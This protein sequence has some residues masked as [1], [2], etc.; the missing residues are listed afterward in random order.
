MKPGQ[1]KRKSQFFEFFINKN[2][3]DFLQKTHVSEFKKKATM[4]FRDAANGVFDIDKQGQYLSNDVL[5]SAMIEEAY[6]KMMYYAIHC[7]ALNT[8]LQLNPQCNNDIVQRIITMDYNSHTA[9]V[10]LYENLQ[11][12]LYTKNLGILPVIANKIKSVKYNL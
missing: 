6:Q 1:Q 2:G 12:L 5:L 10:I 8:M 9:Y 4:F 11:Q 3:P 7:Q